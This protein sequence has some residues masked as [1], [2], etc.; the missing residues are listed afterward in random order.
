MGWTVRFDFSMVRQTDM[1]HGF[2]WYEKVGQNMVRHA[3][4]KW[5]CF[6]AVHENVQVRGQVALKAHPLCVLFNEE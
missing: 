1:A 3:V 5:S 2:D 6:R 4:T